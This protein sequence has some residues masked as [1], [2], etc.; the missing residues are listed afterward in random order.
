MNGIESH[1]TEAKC[2]TIQGMTVE[3]ETN[4]K[5]EKQGNNEAGRIHDCGKPL[6]GF[7]TPRVIKEIEHRY[8]S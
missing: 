6:G 4:L 1:E 5:Y 3:T 2:H 8:V 7:K